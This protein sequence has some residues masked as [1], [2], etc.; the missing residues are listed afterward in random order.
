MSRIREEE[1]GTYF[2]DADVGLF[3]GFVNGD[4]GNF[5]DPIL[6]FVRYMWDYLAREREKSEL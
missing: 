1:S 6:N 4:F 5:L 2:D 3:A